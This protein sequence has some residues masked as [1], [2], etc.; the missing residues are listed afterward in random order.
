MFCNIPPPLIYQSTRWVG[1]TALRQL[2]ALQHTLRQTEDGDIWWIYIYIYIYLWK[3]IGNFNSLQF[4]APFSLYRASCIYI[5]IYIYMLVCVLVCVAIYETMLLVVFNLIFY[6]ILMKATQGYTMYQRLM[7]DASYA[8]IYM[9]THRYI[10]IYYAYKHTCMHSHDVFF[11]N[12]LMR[13]IHLLESLS[14]V[15]SVK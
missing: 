1:Q 9:H 3:K 4:F 5:Y 14:F 10:H 13:V 6:W 8:N 15:G 7:C 2:Q 12:M 11:N